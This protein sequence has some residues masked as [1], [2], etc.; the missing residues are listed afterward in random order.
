MSSEEYHSEKPISTTSFVA[1]DL[2]AWNHLQMAEL[3]YAILEYIQI[4][5]R[6]PLN[7]SPIIFLTW[8]PDTWEE[9][10]PQC[11][12]RVGV[13]HNLENPIYEGHGS[14]LIAMVINPVLKVCDCTAQDRSDSLSALWREF[15]RKRSSMKDQPDRH[16][17]AEWWV[18]L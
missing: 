13:F 7:G 5:H 3:G 15:P 8:H 4:L 9:S 16:Q 18:R 1:G 10:K 11:G 6:G 17:W 14:C 12:S 2:S